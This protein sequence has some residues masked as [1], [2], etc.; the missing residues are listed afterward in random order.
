MEERRDNS[1]LLE[2][3]EGVA[4]LTERVTNYHSELT[5]VKGDVDKLEIRQTSSEKFQWK[6]V[7]IVTFLIALATATAPWVQATISGK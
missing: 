2:I 7:G 4:V 1:L 3:K 6:V 5:E